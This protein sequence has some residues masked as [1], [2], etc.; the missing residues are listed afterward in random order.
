MEE[1]HRARCGGPR[2]GRVRCTSFLALPRLTCHT[3]VFTN[4]E[5]PSAEVQGFLWRV[6]CTGMID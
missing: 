5:A 4:P 2:G 3:D 6:H 1:M